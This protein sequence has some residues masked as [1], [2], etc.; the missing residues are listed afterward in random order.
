MPISA[1]PQKQSAPALELWADRV[2]GLVSG[3]RKSA[4]VLTLRRRKGA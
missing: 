3:E 4:K 1:A 2:M